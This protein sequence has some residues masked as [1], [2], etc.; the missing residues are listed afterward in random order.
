MTTLS[1]LTQ[2]VHPA[3]RH[4]IEPDALLSDLLDEIDLWGLRDD[5][6]HETGREISDAELARW[7]TVGDVVELEGVGA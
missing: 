4:L 6:E 5:L 7:E 3:A 2:R 1:I